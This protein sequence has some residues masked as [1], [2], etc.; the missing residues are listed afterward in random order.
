MKKKS[1]ELLLLLIVVF[2]D[3]IVSIKSYIVIYNQIIY[4]QIIYNQII[5]NQ[6][7]YNQI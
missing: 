1:I 5:Y 6:I 3:K 7:I 4:N 2:N